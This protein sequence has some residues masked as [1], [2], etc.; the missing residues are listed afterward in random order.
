MSIFNNGEKIYNIH[1]KS[2]PT[3]ALLAAKKSQ[4]T[5][6][7]VNTLIDNQ[8]HTDQVSCLSLQVYNFFSS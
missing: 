3:F 8:R 1:I 5:E 7:G 4:K 6:D 2:T